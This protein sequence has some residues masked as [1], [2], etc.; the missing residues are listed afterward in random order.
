MEAPRGNEVK[1]LKKQGL[2]AEVDACVCKQQSQMGLPRTT[3]AAE[4]DV[5]PN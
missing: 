3:E 1:G 2:C 4:R 5:L